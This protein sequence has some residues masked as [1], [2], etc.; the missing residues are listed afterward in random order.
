MHDGLRLYVFNG[1][2][3][4]GFMTAVLCNDF[5][6]ACRRADIENQR[7]L[8]CYA[9]FFAN[10]MPVESYGSDEAVKAWIDSGGIEGQR[11]E[12]QAKEAG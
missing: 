10:Y 8:F 5:M 12:L 9:M 1:I 6:D 2:P 4:G 7:R 11:R 3:P